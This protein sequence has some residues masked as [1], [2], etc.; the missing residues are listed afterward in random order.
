MTSLIDADSL[1][2]VDVG[3]IFTRAMLFDVVDGIYRFLA[4]GTAST[5]ADAPFLNISEGVRMAVDN[6]QNLSGRLLIGADEQLIMPSASD[7]SGVDRFAATISAGGPLKTV[8]VG[9]LDGVSVESARRLAATMYCDV[10]DV[11]SLNDRRKSAARIDTILR[12][13]PDL[14]VVAGG[15][16][17]QRG[18][19]MEV[20]LGIAGHVHEIGVGR[21][22]GNGKMFA[23]LFPGIEIQQGVGLAQAV[24]DQVGLRGM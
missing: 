23:A 4:T 9:L 6:L 18:R 21:I 2:V 17:I 7:G 15:T 19:I 14:I 13:R 22:G 1:L 11:I 16:V 5:T 10:K 24:L 20:V 8:V 12:L 3:T